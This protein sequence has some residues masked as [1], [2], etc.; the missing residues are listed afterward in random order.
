[1]IEQTPNL[2]FIVHR[3]RHPHFMFA[4]HLMGKVWYR[5]GVDL[6]PHTTYI[7]ILRLV[8]RVRVWDRSNTNQDLGL[9]EDAL[10]RLDHHLTGVHSG[11]PILFREANF[12]RYESQ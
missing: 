6:R 7:I 3:N 5:C 9:W 1:M 2:I 12:C 10:Q 4:H 8:S 11:S